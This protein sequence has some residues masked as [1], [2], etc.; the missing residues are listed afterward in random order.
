MPLLGV[1]KTD[2]FRESAFSVSRIIPPAFDH[3]FTLC[4]LATRPLISQSPLA[5]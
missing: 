3:G 1:R 5:T 4:T 2:A